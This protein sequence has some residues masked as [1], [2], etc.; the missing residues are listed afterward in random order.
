MSTLFDFTNDSTDKYGLEYQRSLKHEVAICEAFSNGITGSLSGVPWN[1][2]FTEELELRATSN[3]L[4]YSRGGTH[5]LNGQ[6]L[7]LK[8]KTRN[9]NFA[10]RQSAVVSWN[11]MS[12]TITALVGEIVGGR[13]NDKV[14]LRAMIPYSLKSSIR[15]ENHFSSNLHR[16]EAIDEQMCVC[17]HFGTNM[18][19]FNGIRFED[20]GIGWL[21]YLF[22]P[23]D[24]TQPNFLVV[25]SLG[26]VGYDRFQA[27]VRKTVSAVGFVTGTYAYGPMFIF[28]VSTGR[29]VAYNGCMIAARNARY[30]LHSL[31]P[32]DYYADRDLKPHIGD[33]IESKLQPIIRSQFERLL[34][35]LDDPAFAEFYYLFQD[36]MLSMKSAPASSR[37]VVYATCLEKGRVWV[38]QMAKVKDSSRA[39]APLLT[40]KVRQQIGKAIR[41]VLR[42][43]GSQLDAKELAIVQKRLGG[44]YS[45][46]NKDQLKAAYDYFGIVLTKRDEKL[47][48]LRN[49]IL[50]GVNV[51]KAKFDPKRPGGRYTDESERI[52]FGFHA[53]IW[54]LIMAAIGYKGQYRD[55][56]EID[57]RFRKNRTNGD[58]PM[59]KHVRIQNDA[60]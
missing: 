35:N 24:K 2:R 34:T 46:P 44:L 10:V 27:V 3:A 50:H 4:S 22:Q 48:N 55:V 1:F 25:E 49:S 31:N 23:S 13:A 14:R 11:F 60:S 9:L 52:C 57:W 36:V 28:G 20:G 12:H 58:K 29:L 19:L 42:T 43:H 33:K 38:D 18:C 41:A 17:F 47:L 6:T 30:G 16:A 54:R 51:I 56:A 59:M 15:F 39:S 21:A 53:L 40:K 37:L 7:S 32:Y 26:G 5:T 45:P 8:V